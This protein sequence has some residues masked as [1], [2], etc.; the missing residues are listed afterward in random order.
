MN[1]CI[2]GLTENEERENDGP[3]KLQGMKLQEKKYGVNRDNITMKCAVFC[4]CSFF[5][6]TT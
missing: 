5:K 3:S 6:H 1:D 4:C 2:Y